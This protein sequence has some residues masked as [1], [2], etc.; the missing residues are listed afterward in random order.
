MKKINNSSKGLGKKTIAAM[1]EEIKRQGRKIEAWRRRKDEQKIVNVK[2]KK[3]GKKD[4][5]SL[6]RMM[7]NMKL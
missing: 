2:K 3:K 1:Y 5:K 7:S 4:K 6:K